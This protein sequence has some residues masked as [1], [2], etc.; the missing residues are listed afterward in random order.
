MTYVPDLS[1]DLYPTFFRT[2]IH[3]GIQ[4]NYNRDD[5]GGKVDVA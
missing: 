1:S 3:V 4:Y 2:L 5:S